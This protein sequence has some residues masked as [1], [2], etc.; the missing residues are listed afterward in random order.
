MLCVRLI[1]EIRSGN[2]P[3]V[4]GLPW[5][6]GAHECTCGTYLADGRLARELLTYT[7]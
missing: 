4:L 7:T 5:L 6:P 3:L 2:E 1:L